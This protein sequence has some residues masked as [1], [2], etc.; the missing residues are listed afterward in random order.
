MNN[1][2]MWARISYTCTVPIASYITLKRTVFGKQSVYFTGTG[3]RNIFTIL[4]ALAIGCTGKDQFGISSRLHWK[5][6]FGIS[7][8]FHWAIR[9][10]LRMISTLEL[11]WS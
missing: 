8:R 3:Y 1:N 7:S 4:P 9:L 6:Q 2:V 11:H 10:G 5:A